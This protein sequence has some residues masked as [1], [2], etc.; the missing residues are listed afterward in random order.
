MHCKIELW[1]QNNKAYRVEQGYPH[2]ENIKTL[3][4]KRQYVL[5]TLDILCSKQIEEVL[6]EMRAMRSAYVD[7]IIK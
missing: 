3:L 5:E 6:T 7:M 1:H 2:M 4:M